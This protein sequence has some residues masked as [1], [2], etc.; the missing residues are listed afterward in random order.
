MLEIDAIDQ[1][2]GGSHIL[3][4]VSLDVPVGQVSVLLG[5][6]GVGKT[7]LLR[8][9]MGVVPIRGGQIR[10]DGRRIDRLTPEKRVA[11]GIGYVPQGRAIFGRLTVAETLRMGADPLRWRRR[12]PDEPFEPLP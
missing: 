11:M 5:R 3:R 2:Y 10:L 1:F 6:N 4:R 7:T 12:I 9:I 8:S